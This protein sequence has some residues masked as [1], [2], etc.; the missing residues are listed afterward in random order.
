METPYVTG[1]Y[2]VEINFDTSR[3]PF[4]YINFPTWVHFEDS[5]VQS[6]AVNYP[7]V[8][9]FWIEELPSSA[10]R[11]GNIEVQDLDPGDEA[12]LYIKQIG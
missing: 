12:Q 2:Y 7:G 3:N 10:P 4:C 5:D 11:D 1:L 9:G 8:Y 6:G